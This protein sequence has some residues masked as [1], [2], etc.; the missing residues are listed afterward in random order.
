MC[1]R[2]GCPSHIGLC[3][4]DVERFGVMQICECVTPT[5]A[6]LNHRQMRTRD[7]IQQADIREAVQK[8]PRRRRTMKYRKL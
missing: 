6:S 1:E 5:Q 3:G 8:E 2:C 4:A 7:V